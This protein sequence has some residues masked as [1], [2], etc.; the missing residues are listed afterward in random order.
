MKNRNAF[1]LVGIGAIL[2]VA[3]LYGGAS[4]NADNTT[5]FGNPTSATAHVGAGS[6]DKVSDGR[7]MNPNFAFSFTP[8][9]GF[10]AS[11]FEDVDQA[12]T[13]VTTI[14]IDDNTKNKGAQIVISP[15][16]EPSDAL[17]LERIKRDIPSMHISDSSVLDV[18]NVGTVIEFTSDNSDFGG[19]SHE[20]WFVAHNDLYQM[21][22]YAENSA[23]LEAILATWKFQ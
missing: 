18:V 21:S 3:L 17:A 14:I 23:V 8:P 9:S 11:S 22:T 7:Y 20:V 2:L 19:K 4:K 10:V 5:P 16:D 1:I 13:A 12:G 6:G 15:W